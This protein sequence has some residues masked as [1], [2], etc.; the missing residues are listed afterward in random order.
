VAQG[1]V[2]NTLDSKEEMASF[3]ER[4]RSEFEGW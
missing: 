4:R 2:T 1:L 3:V